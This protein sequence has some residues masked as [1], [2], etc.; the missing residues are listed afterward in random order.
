MSA[1]D[2]FSTLRLEVSTEGHHSR[3][4][5]VQ[6]KECPFCGSTNYHLGFNLYGNYFSCWKCGGLKTYD[7]LQAL[8]ADRVQVKEFFQ[9]RERAEGPL[10]Q[11]KAAGRL[12]EPKSRG[13]LLSAHREYLE[14]RKFDPAYL[15]RVWQIEGIAL[16]R[17]LGWRIYIPV[18]R[19]GRRVSW[20]A[21]ALHDNTVRYLS[22]SEA[23]EARPHKSCVYG[24]DLASHSIVIVEGPTDAWR[25]GPGAG[26]LFGT[27]FTTAQ[28]RELSRYLYRFILFDNETAAQRQA[29]KLADALACFP[30]ETTILEC[31]A[32]DPGSMKKEE[33]NRLRRIARLPDNTY[34][35]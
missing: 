9:D 22:A 34:G 11:T 8:G 23:E 19:N 31:D 13:P 16:D 6:L 7:V 14:K 25:I 33:L 10:P 18:I 29:R 30:G 15:Q 28:V 2:L 1:L 12:I 5:W 26:A 20:T 4:G 24:A 17:K 3:P 21:R 35:S 32:K 27:S